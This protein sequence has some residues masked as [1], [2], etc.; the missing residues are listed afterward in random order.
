MFR[1][2][3]VKPENCLQ[4]KVLDNTF[5]ILIFFLPFSLESGDDGGPNVALNKT[6]SSGPPFLHFFFRLLWVLRFCDLLL[7]ILPFY[8]FTFL[9]LLRNSV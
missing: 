1:L 2:S 4:G 7:G 6:P 8:L 5:D 9:P 3:A